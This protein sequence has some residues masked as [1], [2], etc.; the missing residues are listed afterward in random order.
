MSSPEIEKHNKVLENFDAFCKKI[1]THNEKIE[2][3]ERITRR[4]FKLDI[5]ELGYILEVVK[6]MIKD[7]YER[8]FRAK[9]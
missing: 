6:A 1:D 4:L 8:D 9:K 5:F 3:V 2:L 7:R